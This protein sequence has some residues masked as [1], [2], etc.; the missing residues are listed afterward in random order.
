MKMLLLWAPHVLLTFDPG[1]IGEASI[2]GAES[3]AQYQPLVIDDWLQHL[4][5][6]D[7]SGW[8]HN[9]AVHEVGDGVGHVRIRLGQEG[10]QTEHLGR[11][12]W[13]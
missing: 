1:A 12:G 11:Q 4:W 7:V 9:A 5:I 6:L 10:L 3:V 2:G 13:I 8:D